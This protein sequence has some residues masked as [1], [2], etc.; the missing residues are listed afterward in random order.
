MTVAPD[1]CHP[2]RVVDQPA[3]DALEVEVAQAGPSALDWKTLLRDLRAR[4]GNL[5]AEV[6]RT[7][8]D[9]GFTAALDAMRRFWHY[10][11]FN[12]WMISYECP[13]ATR[14]AGRSTWEKMGRH[15]LPDAKPIYIFAPWDGTAR[16]YVV[17]PV[18]DVKQTRGKRIPRLDLALQGGTRYVRTLERAAGRLGILI[19]VLQPGTRAVGQS[20]GGVIRIASGLP[21]RE[22]ASTLIHELA[23][24]VLHQKDRRK[25]LPPYE[26]RET[27][28]EATSYV[29]LAALGLPSKAPTYIAWQGGSGTMV[30]AA[31]GRI[32]R[33]ARAILEAAGLGEGDAKKAAPGRTKR[34]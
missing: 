26:E 16:R 10:S 30:L 3:S 11:P 22:R 25:K 31:L 33:A 15:V 32:Q 12:S 9:A 27:E 19:E 2:D 21:G 17:V 24:E 1:P 13:T 28:A 7:R 8:Q 20:L 6:D 34:T 5:A 14:V 23:H 29:V 18:F 4:I